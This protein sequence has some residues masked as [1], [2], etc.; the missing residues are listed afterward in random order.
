MKDQGLESERAKEKKTYGVS[1]QSSR[2]K[3]RREWNQRDRSR[4]CSKRELPNLWDAAATR[5]LK[6]GKM[7]TSMG[8]CHTEGQ[9]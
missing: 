1:S 9:I 5:S 6:S 2:K 4:R 8:L 7:D 3:T